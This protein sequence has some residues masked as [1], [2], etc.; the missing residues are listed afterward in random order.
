MARLTPMKKL[1]LLAASHSAALA[2]G[3]ALGVYFLPILA[4]PPPIA[5]TALAQAAADASF[6]TTLRRDLPGSDALHWGEGT[7]AVGARSITHTGRLAPGPAYR[8]YLTPEFVQTGADFQ[9][10]KA[11]SVALADIKN[12]DGFIA[13][14]PA[15]VDVAQYRGVLVWCEAFQQFIT[16]GQ[17]R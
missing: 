13:P 1:V 15:G 7:A 9:R 12:F 2:L 14:V 10:I 16:S 4:A 6:H 11:R 3:F 17:Y 5:A 8:L